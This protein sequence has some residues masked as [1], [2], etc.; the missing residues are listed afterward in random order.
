MSAFPVAKRHPMIGMD[1][2]ATWL[3]AAADGKA[4]WTPKTVREMLANKDALFR[5]ACAANPKAQAKSARRRFYT[6]VQLLR[7]NFPELYMAVYI[8]HQR[9]RIADKTA[10]AP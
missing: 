3:N 8:W 5:P 9:D 6:T 10:S 4:S 1:E 7:A 2:L